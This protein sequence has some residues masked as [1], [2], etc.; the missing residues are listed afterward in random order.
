MSYAAHYYTA[1]AYVIEQIRWA[2]ATGLCPICRQRRRARWP[3]GELRITCGNQLCF[4][5]WL[6]V[7]TGA[8]EKEG[9]HE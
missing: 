4:R 9:E 5:R 7:R 6:P 8:P 2:G 3:N 1:Q